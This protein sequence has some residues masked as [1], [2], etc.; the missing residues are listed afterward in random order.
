M[1]KQDECTVELLGI[2]KD[3]KVIEWH[4]IKVADAHL[5]LTNPLFTLHG[6]RIPS[7]CRRQDFQPINPEAQPDPIC[8][9]LPGEWEDCNGDCVP[10]G[11]K[12]SCRIADCAAVTSCRELGPQFSLQHKFRKRF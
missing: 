10:R 4:R 3:R 6:V 12:C 9:Y 1:I 7:L 8:S 11:R 5:S 2:F